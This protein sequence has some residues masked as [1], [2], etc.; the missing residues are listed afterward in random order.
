[1]LKI[2][3]G[4]MKVV[5]GALETNFKTVSKMVENAKNMGADLVV[6]PE[7]CISGS[8]VG[9]RFLDEAFCNELEEYNEKIRELSDSIG[10]I[11]GSVTQR[12]IHGIQYGRDGRKVRYNAALFAYK[13]RWM[14]HENSSLYEGMYIKQFSA[15]TR[16]SDESR[17]FLSANDLVS[18]DGFDKEANQATFM[19]KDHRLGVLIGEDLWNHEYYSDITEEYT[20]LGAKY[21]INIAASPWYNGKEMARNKQILNKCQKNALPILF[22]VN[23]VGCQNTGKNVLVFDGGSTIYGHFGDPI[24]HCNDAFV[25]ELKLY[26]G[27]SEPINYC[28]NKLLEA[29]T[30]GIRE[31]DAQV[32]PFAPKWVIGLS[33]GL[34][35]CVSCALLVRAL[36]SERVLGYN[37]ATD[38]NSQETIGNAQ[39]LARALHVE[40]RNGNIEQ[41]VSAT[42]EVAIKNYGYKEEDIKPFAMENVQ[43][44]IRGHLLSTFAAIHNGVISNNGNKVEALLGYCTLYGDTIGALA[45]LGDLLKTDLFEI[46][47]QINEEYRTEVIPNR[48]LPVVTDSGYEWEMMPSAELKEKQKDPMKWFYHDAIVDYLTMYPNYGAEK[49]ARMYATGELSRD[50]RFGKW[51][52][53]Y[54]LD[55]DPR[56]FFE[57]LE[58]ILKQMRISVFK[59]VQMPPILTVSKGAFGNDFRECQ[60]NIELSEEY[61]DI[62]ER[63]LGRRI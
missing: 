18:Y 9:D 54:G 22:Y 32:F 59:R 1:M 56:A 16:F 36:G 14:A 37:L 28:N 57:D 7:L 13:G 19:F 45:I 46:S 23:S 48:L 34:D 51:L 29:L 63:L 44:R 47:K 12:E 62:R 61:L 50:A 38:Y 20:R 24:M 41:L 31:F 25:E 10:I 49:L 11:W 52:R 17:Y 6:F 21:I 8:F 40:I 39:N 15:N 2:A 3:I 53:F 26:E 5:P 30:Y 4:Q 58:W 35:S 33:G 42:R 27:R 55:L 43:A 60:I